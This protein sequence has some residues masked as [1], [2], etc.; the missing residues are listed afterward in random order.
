MSETVFVLGA[1]FSEPAR[2][3]LARDLITPTILKDLGTAHL[4]TVWHQALMDLQEARRIV[5]LGYSLPL[6]DFEFRHTLLKAIAG[7]RDIAVR[8]V[9]Y[10]PDDRCDLRERVLRDQEEERYRNFFGGRDL[11]FRYM[12]A[13]E[14]MTSSDVLW[15][16]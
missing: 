4:K 10:P 13:A 6:S 12:D 2:M 15:G 7:R 14:A 3:P 9:L 5:L 1:G 11:A 16:W 8:V